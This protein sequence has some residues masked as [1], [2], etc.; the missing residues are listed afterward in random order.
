MSAY[1][2]HDKLKGLNGANNTVGDFIEWLA[3]NGYVIAEWGDSGNYLEAATIGRDAL[4][5]LFFE[6]NP[7]KLEDEKR[8]MLDSLTKEA[9]G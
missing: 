8:A 6:I 2:E 7:R 1:P 4:I 9:N 3:E 5:A